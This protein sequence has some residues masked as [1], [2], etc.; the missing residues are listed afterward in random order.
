MQLSPKLQVS[1]VSEI[2]AIEQ[3]NCEKKIENKKFRVGCKIMNRYTVKSHL[4]IY[5]ADLRIS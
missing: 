5:N 4:L 2:S 3:P 1:K